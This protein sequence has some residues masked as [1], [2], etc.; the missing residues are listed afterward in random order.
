LFTPA[1]GRVLAFGGSRVLTDANAV[2]QEVVGRLPDRKVAV[3]AAAALAEV[4]AVPGRVLAGEGA[5]RQFTVTEGSPE[6]AAPLVA[7]AY[8]DLDAAAATL[9]HIRVTEQVQQTAQALAA[10]GDPGRGVQ[11]AAS[12]ADTLEARG[13]LPTVVGEVRA[14]AASLGS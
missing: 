5:D 7:A 13:V 14:T 8:G 6:Q 10:A 11:L 9:G 12:L 1:V 4:A 3:H 2:L